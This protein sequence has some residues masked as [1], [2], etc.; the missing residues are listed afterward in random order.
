MNAISGSLLE[1]HFKRSRIFSE[2]TI[3]NK[4]KTSAYSYRRVSEP[5]TDPEKLK[6]QVRAAERWAEVRRL[7]VSAKAYSALRAG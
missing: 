6:K 1:R 5:V 2:M 3:E 7:K 4:T